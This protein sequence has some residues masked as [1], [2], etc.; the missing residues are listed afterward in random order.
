MCEYYCDAVCM[1]NSNKEEKKNYAIFLVKSATLRIP[2]RGLAIVQGLT[3][4]GEKM[5][6]RV[7]R[8][9]DEDK[10][11]AGKIQLFIAGILTVMC[12]CSFMTIFVYS[13]TQEQDVQ[14]RI[15][16]LQKGNGIIFMEKMFRWEMRLLTLVNRPFYLKQSRE[17]SHQFS[18]RI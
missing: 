5:Q 3:N 14:P 6:E 12:L 16:L 15:I 11:P 10:K 2:R 4:N 8:I 1:Q 18:S 7:D 13:A 17:K 9:L